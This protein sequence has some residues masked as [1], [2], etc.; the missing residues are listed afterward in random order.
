MRTVFLAV[1]LSAAVASPASAQSFE[2][3]GLGEGRTVEARSIPVQVRGSITVD[4]A[5]DPD[6]G[7][8]VAGLCGVSGSA[9]YTLPTR[10]RLGWGRGVATGGRQSVSGYLTGF[11]DRAT[12]SSQV[13]RVGADGAEHPCSDVR[14]VEEG[15]K[16]T[17]GSSALTLGPGAFLLSRCGAPLAA[18]V[19][20]LIPTRRLSLGVLRAGNTTVDLRG[21]GPFAA[22]PFKGSVRSSL[23]LVLGRAKAERTTPAPLPEGSG[24]RRVRSRTVISEWSIARVSGE[25]RGTMRGVA[26]ALLCGPLDAC[27]ASGAVTLFPQ[28][29]SGRFALTASANGRPSWRSLEAAVGIG[30]ARPPRNLDFVY[31]FGGWERGTGTLASEVRLGDG[32]VCRDQAPSV[33]GGLYGEA[34]R[35]SVRTEFYVASG[36]STRCPGPGLAADGG[37]QR[38]ARGTTPL[39]AFGG[40]TATI[41]LDRG[42]TL[43]DDA[44]T[45]AASSKVT[46]DLRRERVR[47]VT[48]TSFSSR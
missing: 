16:L 30:P 19:A 20:A 31:G 2:A 43:S 45:G 38:L 8:A 3:F 12:T 42:G 22:G 48:G 9:T 46:I 13:T 41:V 24:L 34:S 26:E 11:F 7:C 44:W 27:G 32:T 17:D 4:W 39:N 15:I 18:D 6:G 29:S 1:V 5:G 23:T 36:Q 14:R 37:A 35:R 40:S 25:V 10:V 28:S 33:L 47:H 21:S